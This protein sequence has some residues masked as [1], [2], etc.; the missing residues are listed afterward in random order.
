MFSKKSYKILP[1][2]I[3]KSVQESNK[4]SPMQPMCVEGSD[5]LQADSKITLISVPDT[6][7]ISKQN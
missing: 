7:Y 5:C 3:G 1:H 4:D 2:V 6:K